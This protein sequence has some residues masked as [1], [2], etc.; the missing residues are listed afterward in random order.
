VIPG[1]LNIDSWPWAVYPTFAAKEE[2]FVNSVEMVIREPGR[3]ERH[4]L[5]Q[6]D[7][8]IIAAYIERTRLRSHLT[9]ILLQPNEDLRAKML[10]DLLA[11]WKEHNPLA[12]GA[13]VEFWQVEVPL[14]PPQ[15]A[16]P[17]PFKKIGEI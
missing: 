16:T 2:S 10:T 14:M 9:L 6:N 1:F 3:E 8:T 13:K 15:T 12:E 17:V 4:I 11:T 5:L 7:P